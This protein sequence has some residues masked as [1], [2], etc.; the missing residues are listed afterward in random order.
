MICPFCGKADDK[1]LDSRP[2][3]GGRVIR[4][5]RQCLACNR[6]FTSYERVEELSRLTVIKRDGSRVPFDREKIYKGVNIAFG[7]RPV[8]QPAREKIVDEVEEQIHRE[9]DREVESRVIGALVCDKLR[10]VDEVAYI[11]FASEHYRF[12][13]IEQLKRELADLDNRPRAMKDQ[14]RLF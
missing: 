7:K 8:P 2:S 6:R 1:V 14:A 11:R 13:D 4:R 5:R 3:D 9:F 12:E 10:A